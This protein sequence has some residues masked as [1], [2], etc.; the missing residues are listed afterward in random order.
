M[1]L[2]R[3]SL[4]FLMLIASSSTL[5]AVIFD[6]G[7][8]NGSRGAGSDLDQGQEAADDFVLGVLGDTITGVS[9]SGA[10]HAT[11][12]PVAND[13]FTIRFYSSALPSTPF[14]SYEVGNSVN[15]V[16]SGVDDAFWGL[17]IFNYSASIPVTALTAGTTYWLSI[18]NNTAG[19]SDDWL[20]ELSGASGQLA[21][22]TTPT[23][24]WNT[25][26]GALAFQ[27]DGEVPIPAA[28]WLFG[29]AL[30]GLGALKRKKA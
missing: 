30:L 29:S 11:N 20:W 13:D 28:A 16:D 12:T 8:P 26:G 25:V 4:I 7:G 21:F 18:V 23:D 19:A 22:R 2:L 15:R 10:Y 9:W 27:L 5:A 3:V 14:L 6:N 1:S 17:D 24:S